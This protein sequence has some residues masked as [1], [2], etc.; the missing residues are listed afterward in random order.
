MGK[1]KESPTAKSPP[2]VSNKSQPMAVCGVRRS[3]ALRVDLG[4]VLLSRIP[5]GVQR[6]C[7]LSI[8]V[9]PTELLRTRTIKRE[10]ATRRAE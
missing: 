2:V 1:A 10:D 9:V 8:E 3:N 6:R 5:E 7:G 4:V